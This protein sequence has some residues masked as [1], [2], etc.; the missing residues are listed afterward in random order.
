MAM[1]MAGPVFRPSPG[2]RTEP[3]YPNSE[4]EVRQLESFLRAKAGFGVA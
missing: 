2:S 3:G 4:G 1:D